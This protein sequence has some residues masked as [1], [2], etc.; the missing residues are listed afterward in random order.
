MGTTTENS[1]CVNGS[2]WKNSIKSEKRLSRNNPK[3]LLK[4]NESLNPSWKVIILY[5]DCVSWKWDK[6]IQTIIFTGSDSNEHCK[7]NVNWLLEVNIYQNKNILKKKN[8]LLYSSIHL[9][10][11]LAYL[12]HVTTR[13][14]VSRYYDMI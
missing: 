7:L 10:T 8:Q 14:S 13:C 12:Y 1:S 4:D 5:P 2:L 9:C 11:R 3:L 6:L